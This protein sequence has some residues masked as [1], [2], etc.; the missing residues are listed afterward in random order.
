MIWMPDMT[1]L[2]SGS[3][4]WMNLYGN[5]ESEKSQCGG[6]YWC[7]LTSHSAK[8]ANVE[9]EYIH[10]GYEFWVFRYG[11]IDLDQEELLPILDG[12]GVSLGDEGVA[13]DQGENLSDE[14]GYEAL[15]RAALSAHGARSYNS[16]RQYTPRDKIL[17]QL[18]AFSK[19]DIRP[20]P[21]SH[22]VEYML[23]KPVWPTAGFWPLLN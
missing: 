13:Y 23:G 2:Q 6:L 12:W 22:R 19:M 20:V 18:K 21:D 11:S 16:D 14:E 3:A 5:K 15:L 7:P 4:Y 9:F 10:N 17:T 1:K 8:F